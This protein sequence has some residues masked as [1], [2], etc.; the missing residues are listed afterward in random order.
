MGQ[1]IAEINYH[2]ILLQSK[3]IELKAF[4]DQDLK[5]DQLINTNWTAK[6]ILGHLVFWHERFARNA[7]DLAE[8]RKPYPLHGKRSEVNDR[9][10]QSTKNDSMV[11]LLNRLIQAQKTIDDNILNPAFD[12]IPYKKGSRDYSKLEHLSIVEHHIDKHLKELIKKIK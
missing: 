4:F 8:G 2:L 6:N 12:M 1:K 11:M 7:K 5:Y 9:S 3:V 10:V